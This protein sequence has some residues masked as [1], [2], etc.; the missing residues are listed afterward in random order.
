[1][2]FSVN[3]RIVVEVYQKEGL[4]AKVQGGIATPGQRDGLKPLKVLVGAKLSD[5][6]LIP[7]GALVYVPEEVL[8]NHAWATKALT[9]DT[10][11]GKFIVLETSYIV[12]YEIPE[13]NLRA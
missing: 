4:R 11:P 13:G 1:M 6:T 10:I 8:H 2:M 7:Q 9:C 5:G 12:C 3:N